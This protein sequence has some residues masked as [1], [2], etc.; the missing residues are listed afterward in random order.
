M[1]PQ[2]RFEKR[3][4]LGTALIAVTRTFVLGLQP[5]NTEYSVFSATT[6]STILFT[7]AS[8]RVLYSISLFP[9]KGGSLSLL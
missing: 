4:V 7:T 1:V 2:S 9:S 8:E 3:V 6:I 5:M